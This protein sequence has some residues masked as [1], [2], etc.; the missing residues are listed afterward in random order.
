MTAKSTDGRASFTPSL[1]YSTTATAGYPSSRLG[2]CFLTGLRI[3]ARTLTIHFVL[4]NPAMRLLVRA[5][6]MAHSKRG[7]RVERSVLLDEILCSLDLSTYCWA[8]TTAARK[9]DTYNVGDEAVQESLREILFHNNTQNID[10][11]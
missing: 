11:A 5:E 4:L 2:I 8:W 7:E 6:C 1:S 9:A 10:L 3:R